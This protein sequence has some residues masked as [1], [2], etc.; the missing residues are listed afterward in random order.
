MENE[1][2]ARFVASENGRRRGALQDA[3]GMLGREARN[4]PKTLACA[5]LA[6]YVAHLRTCLVKHFAHAGEPG[7]R[8]FPLGSTHRIL[9]CLSK[10]LAATLSEA[11]NKCE[12]SLLTTYSCRH[13]PSA[14]QY[15]LVDRIRVAE[16]YGDR[17]SE[18]MEAREAAFIKISS[19][20]T[21]ARRN[22]RG[23]RASE[24]YQEAER[25][26]VA[27]AEFLHTP[28]ET[29]L[30]ILLEA[31]LACE[32]MSPRDI[33]DRVTDASLSAVAR[34]LSMLGCPPARVAELQDAVRVAR[35]ASADS[36][37]L[38]LLHTS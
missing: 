37:S 11:L 33:S 21:K 19:A 23:S 13:F 9:E 25:A 29:E 5:R 35:L 8:G 14:K 38:G 32:A 36:F 28:S 1:I 7:W 15:S 2:S 24:F 31:V 6:P 17:L 10:P 12:E 4:C 30:S 20:S 34:D 27:I 3:A 26:S 22:G 18:L 16:A